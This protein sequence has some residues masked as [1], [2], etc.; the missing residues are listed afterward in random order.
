[1][2]KKK[3]KKEIPVE[4][5]V[6]IVA[7]HVELIRY[8]KDQGKEVSMRM[9]IEEDGNVDV[10]TSHPDNQW[11]PRACIARLLFLDFASENNVYIK[12]MIKNKPIKYV[13][14]LKTL[15]FCTDILCELALNGV[16]E[17]QTKNVIDT[18]LLDEE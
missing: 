18:T 13:Q 2:S 5:A 7:P 3:T 9:L 1:M 8:V 10:T 14:L 12:E 11:L 6:V 4:D 17:E 15:E 16:K